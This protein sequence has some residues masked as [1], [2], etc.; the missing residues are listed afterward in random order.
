MSWLKTGTSQNKRKAKNFI[1]DNAQRRLN[2][3]LVTFRDQ[4]GN[5]L[6]VDAVSAVVIKQLRA[7]IPCSCC[8]DLITKESA[9][10]A[11]R[12][13]TSTENVVTKPANDNRFA[14]KINTGG[15][16]FGEAGYDADNA[17]VRQ[18]KEIPLSDFV[19]A[20]ESRQ[21]IGEDNKIEQP[22]FESTEMDGGEPNCG[23]CLTT[24]IQPAFEFTGHT[25]HLLSGY[26][27]VEAQGYNVL[28]EDRPNTF[29]QIT[30]DGY[31]EYIIQIPKYFTKVLFSIRDNLKIVGRQ[32]GQL[33][34]RSGEELNKQFFMDNR[35]QEVAIRIKNVK[36]FTH[37][38][39]LF[40]TNES[41]KNANI[42][43]EQDVINYENE[44]T[45]GD[46]TVILSHNI[47]VVR[48]GDY[49]SIPERNLLLKVNS[50][51]RK[52]VAN[53]D[54]WEWSVTARATQRSESAYNLFKHYELR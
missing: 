53:K 5:A 9:F 38:Y 10:V 15:S 21:A 29:N 16:K 19:V 24:N 23:I 22:V 42:G 52:S 30:D 8:N 35:G 25:F 17:S 28:I 33:T 41:V 27:V 40:Q 45:I 36:R 12:Y 20:S 51:V 7:G 2:Q 18:T 14:V 50:A 48:S 26:N 47:G 44:V 49:I 37:A 3:E 13:T 31:L 4:I 32:P 1:S 43:E 34:Q 11:N 39:I 54:Q 46:L 6:A